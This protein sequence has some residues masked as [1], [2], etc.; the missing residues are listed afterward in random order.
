MRPV[1]AR[2]DQP[3]QVGVEDLF[4]L[5]RIDRHD[6]AEEQQ[7]NDGDDQP[8]NQPGKSHAQ[9]RPETQAAGPAGGQLVISAKP[10]VHHRG[11][12]QRRDRERVGGHGRREVG[13]D[14]S[15]LAGVEALLRERAQQP[16]EAE[17]AGQGAGRHHEDLD[18]VPEDV[19]EQRPAHQRTAASDCEFTD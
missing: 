13:E 7:L 11:G 12:E 10:T 8:E 6:E 4:N 5:Q 2:H 16:A 19:P 18:E 3:G 17:D 15:H 1:D 9:E 14:L